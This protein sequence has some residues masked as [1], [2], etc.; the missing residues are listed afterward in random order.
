M[1]LS[2]AQSPQQ[3]WRQPST[4][5]SLSLRF[6][7]RYCSPDSC[8]PAQPDSQLL[9]THPSAAGAERAALTCRAGSPSG[10][11]WRC[12][13]PSGARPMAAA[14]TR[15]RGTRGCAPASWPPP[16][17]GRRP[18]I[19][20]GLMSQAQC[21]PF[22]APTPQTNSAAAAGAAGPVC[23]LSPGHPTARSHSPRA[24]RL[25]PA[26]HSYRRLP[27]QSTTRPPGSQCRS[28]WAPASGTAP[29]LP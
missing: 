3:P 9:S 17:R 13:A 8:S 27:L 10:R 16:A 2:P 19:R 28:A 12:L 4:P 20:R 25:K 11:P 23:T 7:Y 24:S 1:M 15:A 29:T 26:M 5:S 6:G 22:K 21:I 14:R 18:G